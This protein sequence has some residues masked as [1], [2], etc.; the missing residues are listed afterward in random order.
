MSNSDQAVRRGSR[1]ERNRPVG[2]FEQRTAEPKRGAAADPF[3]PAFSLSNSNPAGALAR[4]R[5]DAETAWCGREGGHVV[6]PFRGGALLSEG[7]LEPVGPTTPGDFWCAK[8]WSGAR[9][10]GARATATSCH[11]CQTVVAARRQDGV[12]LPRPRT[13]GRF[14]APVR[15]SDAGLPPVSDVRN[16]SARGRRVKA[17]R[18]FCGEEGWIEISTP[19]P[20]AD[21]RHSWKSRRK[22]HQLVR[23]SATRM[24]NWGAGEREEGWRSH[25]IY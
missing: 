25:A 1:S 11:P 24:E 17:R 16:V 21:A 14:V 8:G 23:A 12:P 4:R 2:D 10:E 3:R 22:I 9:T 20:R 19:C 13:H 5:K 7:A 15:A 6:C 18:G